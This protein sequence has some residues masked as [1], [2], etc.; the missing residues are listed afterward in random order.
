MEDLG[1]VNDSMPLS[2]DSE[3]NSEEKPAPEDRKNVIYWIYLL[4]GVGT[5]LPWQ[6]VLNSMSFLPQISLNDV[7]V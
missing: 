7:S 2:K 5:L 4:Y 3:L 6:A 1:K